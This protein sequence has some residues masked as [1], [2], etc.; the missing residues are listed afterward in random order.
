MMRATILCCCLLLGGGAAAA[1]QRAARGDGFDAFWQKFKAAVVGGDR[2]AA[3][4]LSKFPVGMSYGM[5]S[6]RN[7]ADLRRRYREVFNEQT[8]AARCFAN[9]RPKRDAED[10]KLYRVAC[11]NEAGDE[12]VV[13][14][15][16]LT[17]GGWKFAWLDNLN[18]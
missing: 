18:E 17:R 10:P 15:F 5:R 1:G 7:Q 9:K 3:A 4:R 2:A 12:V 6:I 13:Y 16:E 8:D 11:P 14:G